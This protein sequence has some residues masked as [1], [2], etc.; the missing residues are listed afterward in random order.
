[1]KE[2]E[3]CNEEWRRLMT[4]GWSLS[5]NSHLSQPPTIMSYNWLETTNKRQPLCL[6]GL[7]HILLLGPTMMLTHLCVGCEWCHRPERKMPS[8][9]IA[10]ACCYQEDSPGFNWIIWIHPI[11]ICCYSLLPTFVLDVNMDTSCRV[12]DAI[13]IHP[14]RPLLFPRGCSS[15][16]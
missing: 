3:K 15:W 1:M 10:D 12:S 8:D 9:P 4:T 16:F 2:C 7:C 13:W 14:I 6:M 11:H 5:L